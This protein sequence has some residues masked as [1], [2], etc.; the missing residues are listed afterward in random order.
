M[1]NIYANT[2]LLHSSEMLAD[3]PVLYV[4]D[5]LHTN[6]SNWKSVY[7]IMYVLVHSR[8]DLSLTIIKSN[9][10][11][12][13]AINKYR[14]VERNKW[15]GLLSKLWQEQSKGPAPNSLKQLCWYCTGIENAPWADISLHSNRYMT[16]LL[17]S[18]QH[19]RCCYWIILLMKNVPF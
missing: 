2:S 7:Q 11:T 15:L 4:F 13:I 3:L 19:N 14:M 6:T 1:P 10:V 18:S 9:R 16:F 17:V 12:G 8:F 5:Q